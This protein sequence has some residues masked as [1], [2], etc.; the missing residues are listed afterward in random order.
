MHVPLA[1]WVGYVEGCLGGDVYDSLRHCRAMDADILALAV[2]QRLGKYAHVGV[3][4]NPG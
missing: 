4:P 1:I 3:T 2:G